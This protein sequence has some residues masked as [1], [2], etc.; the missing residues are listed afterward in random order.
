M[1]FASPRAITLCITR[2]IN[3]KIP[4]QTMLLHILTTKNFCQKK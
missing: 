4:K 2:A 3:L 1:H